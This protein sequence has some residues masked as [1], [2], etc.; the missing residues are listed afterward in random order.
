MSD[1]NKK[2]TLG[3]FRDITKD[4][5]DSTLITEGDYDES[6]LTSFEKQLVRDAQFVKFIP[7]RVLQES[8]DE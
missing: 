8:E 2:L 5:P 4:L 6:N 3:Y 7:T 1:T